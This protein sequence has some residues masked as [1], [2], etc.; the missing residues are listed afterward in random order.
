MKQE[1][2][3]ID[4][5]SIII[6]LNNSNNSIIGAKILKIYSIDSNTIRVNLHLKNRNKLNL[7]IDCGHRF[8]V[9]NRYQNSNKVPNSFS[10]FLRK[11][12]MNGYIQSLEQINFDRIIKICIKR[13][14]EIK[15]LILEMFSKGNIILLNSNYNII[16][17]LKSIIDFNYNKYNILDSQKE[18]PLNIEEQKFI[19]ILNEKKNIEFTLSEIFSFGK[20]YTKEILYNIK[21]IDNE[22]PSMEDIKKIY[23]SMNELL[24]NIKNNNLNPQII[25]DNKGNYIDVIPI[26]LNIYKEYNSN[27]YINFYDALDTFFDKINNKQKEYLIDSKENVYERRLK[28][29]ED[30]LKKYEFEAKKNILKANIIYSNFILIENTIKNINYFI[31]TKLNKE[32]ILKKIDKKLKS[33]TINDTTINF[34]LEGEYISINLLKNINQNAN[35]YYNLSKK[36]TKKIIGAK[37]AIHNTKKLLQNKNKKIK[38]KKFI[39]NYKKYWYEKYRWFISSE[40]ILIIGGRNSDDNDEIFKKYIEKRDIIFHTDTPG[41]PLVVLKSNGKTFT[42]KTLLE[43][44]I[45]CVSYSNSWKQKLA[46]SDCYWIHSNQISKTPESGEYIK[47]GSFIIRGKKNYFNN[48]KLELA[49][50]IQ[51]EDYTR[52]IGGPIDSIKNKCKIYYKII[53]GKYN[54]NDISKKLYKLFQ[55]HILDKKFLKEIASPEKISLFIPSGETDVIEN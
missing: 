29:Q 20:I 41:S 55:N 36:Y 40:D 54:L 39:I 8:Y 42:E 31:S 24:M 28:K 16:H 21:N 53:P 19:K 15:Y 18:N 2:T 46:S 38:N 11:H 32:L 25:I 7:I 1:M 5:F 14:E 23:S 47:K 52:V 34:I 45:F 13:K 35:E 4:L 33:I 3:C 26:F 50:G 17:S 37:D 30:I 9:S 10:M 6:E 51:I 27:K 22:N 44:S 12:I 48:I 49:I 43:A